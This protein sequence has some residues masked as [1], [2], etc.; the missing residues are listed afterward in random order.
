MTKK[1][2]L[3]NGLNGVILTFSSNSN[4]GVHPVLYHFLCQLL[5]TKLEDFME[6]GK[7]YNFI[8]AHISST[9]E[10][11]HKHSVGG[12]HRNG[13]AIDISKINGKSITDFYNKDEDVT[14]ICDALQVLATDIREVWENFGPLI[15][16]KTDQKGSINQ[17]KKDTNLITMH[18]SHLHFSVR[19]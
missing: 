15:C 8:S 7:L 6:S 3:P 2:L 9:S 4:A 11:Y 18:K 14:G 19:A 10:P 13:L 17:I 5:T 1:I 12:P 16:F